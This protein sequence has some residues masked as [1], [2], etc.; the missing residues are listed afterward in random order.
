M[1]GAMPNPVLIILVAVIVLI[2]VVWYL[3][4]RYLRSDDEAEFDD[5]AAEHG[6][7]RDGHLPGARARMRREHDEYGA[8]RDLQRPAYA[9]SGAAREVRAVREPQQ[10]R[11]HR[12]GRHGL[13]RDDDRTELVPAGGRVTRSQPDTRR[14]S[15]GPGP[16]SVRSRERDSRAYRDDSRDFGRDSR[17]TRSAPAIREL[18]IAGIDALDRRDGTRP[19]GMPDGRRSGHGSADQQDILPPVKPRQSKAKG[20]RD[21]DGDWPRNEWDELSDVDYWTELAADKPFAADNSGTSRAGRPAGAARS[22]GR[23]ESAK[24]PDQP[25]LPSAGRQGRRDHEDDRSASGSRP[26]SSSRTERMD[27]MRSVPGRPGPTRPESRPAPQPD[28]DPLTSPSFPRVAA[29][30]SRS[31]RRGRSST[32]D[33]P[34][35]G[36]A[37]EYA[38]APTSYDD[39]A[40]AYGMAGAAGYRVPAASHGRSVPEGYLLPAGSGWSAAAGGYPAET[41]APYS[42]TQYSSTQ[43]SSPQYPAPH[44]AEPRHSAAA[45]GSYP[46]Y[47]DDAGAGPGYSPSGHYEQSR[48]ARQAPSGYDALT[49]SYDSLPPSYDNGP[50]G[51]VSEPARYVSEPVSYGQ[52]STGQNG[53]GHYAAASYGTDPGYGAANPG[54]DLTSVPGYGGEAASGEYGSHQQADTAYP[55]QAGLPQSYATPGPPYQYPAASAQPGDHGLPGGYAGADPYAVDPHGYSG[56][57]DRSY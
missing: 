41:T 51:Y 13:Y 12:G 37:T 36:S 5:V 29:D 33:M 50:S 38:A 49:A 34:V 40:P 9:R 20:K 57:G 17:A 53:N 26:A 7:G 6:S 45:G 4:M 19:A 32:Q 31:Y 54:Y 39:P 11:E 8:E 14:G 25:P 21:D 18:A 1:D 10:G 24:R 16:G 3:G 42:S 52:H 30:D 43:Y 22:S 35:A 48:P 27:Q 2:A 55:Y 15:A 46:A 47:Q 44:Y 23:D 28:D 56:Y